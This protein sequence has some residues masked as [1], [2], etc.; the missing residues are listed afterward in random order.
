M[1]IKENGIRKNDQ[2]KGWQERRKTGIKGTRQ[3]ES[4]QKYDI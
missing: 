4:Q 2:S 3:A 1:T